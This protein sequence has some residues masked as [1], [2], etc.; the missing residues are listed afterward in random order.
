MEGA[1]STTCGSP[2]PSPPPHPHPYPPPPFRARPAPGNS[3]GEMDPL[4]FPCHCWAGGYENLHLHGN[5]RNAKP[6]QGIFLHIC[7]LKI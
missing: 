2:S 1:A 6:N 3:G 7:Q 5:L 4:C